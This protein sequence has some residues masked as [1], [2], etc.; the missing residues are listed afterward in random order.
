MKKFSFLILS[1]I[2]SYTTIGQAV[3]DSIKLVVNKMFAAVKSADQEVLLDC[4][5]DSAILQTVAKNKEGK[6]FVSIR[7][8]NFI[9]MVTSV[10][11]ELILFNW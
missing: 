2:L 5:A 8:T 3:E 6:V 4:F 7:L 11:A 10:I 1:V 9:L